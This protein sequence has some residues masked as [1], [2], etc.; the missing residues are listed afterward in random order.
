MLRANKGLKLKSLNKPHLDE[1]VSTGHVLSMTCPV[2]RSWGENASHYT[3][4][5]RFLSLSDIGQKP[6]IL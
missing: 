6:E 1:K 4:F 2:E 5:L 3:E